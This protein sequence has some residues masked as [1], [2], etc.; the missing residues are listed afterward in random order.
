MR[1]QGVKVAK[2]KADA[3]VEE[4]WARVVALYHIGWSGSGGGPPKLV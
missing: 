4:V 1:S 3:S 2:C